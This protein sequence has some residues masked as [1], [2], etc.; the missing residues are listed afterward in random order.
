MRRT[1]N[2]GNCCKYGNVV[3]VSEKLNEVTKDEFYGE[4]DKSITVNQLQRHEKEAKLIKNLKQGVTLGNDYYL[5]KDVRGVN[6]L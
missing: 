6:A 2:I 3:A 5:I 1:Y 4:I